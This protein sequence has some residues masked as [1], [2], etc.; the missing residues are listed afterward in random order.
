MYG[1]CHCENTGQVTLRRP[2]S[3]HVRQICERVIPKDDQ[4]Q[5]NALLIPPITLSSLKTLWSEIQH[6]AT[7]SITHITRSD[8]DVSGG[9]FPSC[10]VIE[11]GVS[12]FTHVGVESSGLRTVVVTI[13]L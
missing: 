8:W 12:Q 11:A 13:K 4:R 6:S 1:A 7:A 5:Q 9:T 3:V 10:R 2:L